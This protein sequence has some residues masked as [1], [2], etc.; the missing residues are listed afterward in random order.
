MLRIHY[1]GQPMDFV[2][3]PNIVFNGTDRPLCWISPIQEGVRAQL[4]IYV[5]HF[6]EHTI[7]IVVEPESAPSATNPSITGVTITPTNPSADNEINITVAIN[8][9]GASFNGRVEGNVWSPSGTGKYLG[10]ENVVIPSGASTVTIIGPAGGAESSYMTHQ[11]GTYLYDVFLENVDQGQVYLN[12]T[13]SKKGV[14]FSVGA[15]ADVYISN[16]SLSAS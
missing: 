13:D 4:M 6:S 2:N 16:V 8:N 7:D 14:S 9:P 10:W 5:P 11:A 12:A 3:D 1:D 15:A